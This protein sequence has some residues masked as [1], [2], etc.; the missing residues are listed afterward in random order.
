MILALGALVEETV[1]KAV[2]ALEETN[3]VLARSIIENDRNIDQKEVEVE[4]ACLKILALYQPVAIDLRYVVA[5]LK[6]NNDLERV[7]D[8]SVNIAERAIALSSSKIKTKI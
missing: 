2:Q 4:E 7:G 6:I 1:L 3:S 8:L 5:V